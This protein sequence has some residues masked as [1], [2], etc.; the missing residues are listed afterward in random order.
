MT[1]SGLF[2]YVRHEDID[3]YHRRG[4]TVVADLGP[5]HGQWSVLMWRCDCPEIA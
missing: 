3:A 1:R 5:V 4:W 2:R